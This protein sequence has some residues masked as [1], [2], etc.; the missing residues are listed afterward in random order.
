M[1]DVV[2]PNRTVVIG[3]VFAAGNWKPCLAVCRIV[4]PPIVS[5]T[6]RFAIKYNLN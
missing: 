4:R 6:F 3:V 5:D 1:C 2:K